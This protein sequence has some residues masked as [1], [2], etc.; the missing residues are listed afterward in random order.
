V[1]EREMERK[2]S[3]GLVYENQGCTNI[4]NIPFKKKYRVDIMGAI[5]M[6]ASFY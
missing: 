1:I 6:R 4:I 2:L 5:L 3:V